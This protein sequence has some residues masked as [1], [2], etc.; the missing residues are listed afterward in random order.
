MFIHPTN[1]HVGP[2]YAPGWGYRQEEYG[3]HSALQSS[4]RWG[5]EAE[6]IKGGA[7]GSLT[8]G[9]N[10]TLLGGP[11]RVWENRFSDAE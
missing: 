9:P 1:R 5:E 3:R 2:T 11:L 10:A 6:L 4:L 8:P 7:V